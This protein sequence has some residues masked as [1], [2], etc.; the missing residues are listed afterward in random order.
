M[1][2]ITFTKCSCSNCGHV[3]QYPA[4]NAGQVV[5]C[6]KCKEKSQLPEPP[7]LIVL[8]PQGPRAPSTKKCPVCDATM[9]FHETA[10]PACEGRR[11][12][13]LRTVVGMA[14][15]VALLGLGWLSLRSFNSP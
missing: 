4:Q 7:P 13:R 5:E 15:A 6:P 12:A 3:I 1:E 9:A 14:S 11:K 10:C 2:I 8:M